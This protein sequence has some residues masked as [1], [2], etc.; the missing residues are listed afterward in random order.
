M[1]AA[2]PFATSR[3]APAGRR[4]GV[5]HYVIV[6][7]LILAMLFYAMPIYVMVVNGL[8]SKSYMTL[9]QMWHLPQGL[10]GNGFPTAWA[11]LSPNLLNSFKIAIPATIVSAMLG[12]LNGYLLSKWKFKGSD[13]IFT[14]ILFGMFIPYQSILVALIQT[15]QRVGLYGHWYGLVVVHIIYGI[16]ICTLIFRNYFTNV[17]NEL[18]EAARV[19]GAGVITAFLQIMLPLALPAF[20]VVG[21]F[22]FTNIWNDFLFGVTV[23]FDPAN[24]PITVALNNLSG[25]NSV[26]WTV[27]MA[28]AVLSALPTALLYI[29]LGRFF[30]RGLLAGSMKG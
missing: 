21:I 29:F 9:D 23:V 16:P 26:D 6:A 13:L 5:G 17:P 15:L 8:K 4:R 28:G 27:V 3:F 2:S 22:Q 11:A 7:I 30:I 20:V 18:L 14:L 19:D 10:A 24:Q 25:T 12:A 1:A